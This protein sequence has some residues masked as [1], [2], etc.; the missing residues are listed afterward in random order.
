MLL[1]FPRFTVLVL[2]VGLTL[3]GTT[4]VRGSDSAQSLTYIQQLRVSTTVVSSSSSPVP[5]CGVVSFFAAAEAEHRLVAIYSPFNVYRVGM[6][7]RNGNVNVRRAACQTLAGWGAQ[8]DMKQVLPELIV[9]LR[10]EDAEVRRFAARALESAYRNSVRD[11]PSAVKP[12]IP[13]LLTLLTEQQ[14]K[15][16]RASALCFVSMGPHAEDALPALKKALK[17]EDFV[18]RIWSACAILQMAPTDADSLT[19]LTDRLHD[20]DA[21]LRM[22]VAGAFA[23]IGLPGVPALTNALKDKNASVRLTAI[24]ALDRLVGRLWTKGVPYPVDAIQSLRQALRDEDKKVA[25][26]AVGALGLLAGLNNEQA[27]DA[28]PQIIECLKH[29]EPLVRFWA[30]YHLRRFGP[31]AHAAIPALREASRTDEDMGVRRS[32]EGTLAALS[33]S[34]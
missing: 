22:V 31:G 29:P 30:A 18:V 21:N 9:A 6:H 13:G 12:A 3:F 34:R 19:L 15:L 14:P 32:A 11:F 27:R 17:D 1:V 5:F 2:V 16:R 10:D 28:V 25:A 7:L 8:F 33:R 23:E 24:L 4:F 26:Q 20:K